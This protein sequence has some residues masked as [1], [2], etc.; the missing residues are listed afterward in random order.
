VVYL[1][2]YNFVRIGILDDRDYRA[3]RRSPSLWPSYVITEA[4]G[5]HL[6]IPELSEYAGGKKRKQGRIWNHPT[7]MDGP[8]DCEPDLWDF[9]RV[10]TTSSTEHSEEFVV[11]LGQEDDRTGK[12]GIWCEI[13][14]GTKGL[15]LGS[16]SDSWHARSKP[17][18]PPLLVHD[19]VKHTLKSGNVVSVSVKSRNRLPAKGASIYWFIVSLEVLLPSGDGKIEPELLDRVLAEYLS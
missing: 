19:R 11:I 5:G 16:I 4:I 6:E 18:S 3:T 12:S 8:I 7:N 13:E 14:A 17:T 9:L 15:S 1:F 10:K 2:L